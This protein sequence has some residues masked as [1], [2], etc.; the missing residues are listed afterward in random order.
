MCSR[1]IAFGAAQQL[2]GCACLSGSRSATWCTR[3]SGSTPSRAGGRSWSHACR[4]RRPRLRLTGVPDSRPSF[5]MPTSRGAAGRVPRWH[6]G[7]GRTR[8]Q[9][10]CAARS[11]QLRSRQV[12]SP[13]LGRGT[14]VGEIGGGTARRAAR[15]PATSAPCPRVPRSPGVLLVSRSYAP[16]RATASTGPA[17]GRVLCTNGP[18]WPDRWRSRRCHAV[19]P[20]PGRLRRHRPRSQVE[21]ATLA[22]GRPV[23]RRWQ[24]L[25]DRVDE[26]CRLLH[27]AGLSQRLGQ[28]PLQHRRTEVVDPP[29]CAAFSPGWPRRDHIVGVASG[30]QQKVGVSQRH[31][32]VAAGV[33]LRGVRRQP[34]PGCARGPPLTGRTPRRAPLARR[35]PHGR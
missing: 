24:L 23:V 22:V 28:V 26:P 11:S 2:P 32:Q 14:A 33:G 17:R 27:P 4:G 20:L 18:G 10:Y 12:R 15:M 9:R 21:Q 19:E 13:G 1:G 6:S 31:V 7:R 5:G 35:G 16:L 30:S 3:A 29:A 34:R 25:G 8:S